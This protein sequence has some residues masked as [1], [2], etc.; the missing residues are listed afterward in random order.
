MILSLIYLNKLSQKE[1]SPVPSPSTS[2]LTS[3][4]PPQQNTLSASPNPFPSQTSTS[5]V[6]LSTDANG[7]S[8][9]TVVIQTKYG[10]IKF[11]F[12]PN[13]APETTKRIIELIQKGFYT[14]LKFHRVETTFVVQGGDPTGTGM[15]GSGQKLKA[16]FN[17]HRHIEGTVAMA[18]SSDPDSA[19][20]QFYISLGT[21]PHLDHS[22]TIFGQ[23][24]EGMDIV[25]KIQV[26]DKMLTVKLE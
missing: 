8:K 16:E 23:V 18:R 17:N 19:D 14:D 20:S 26:G 2:N 1:P 25:R 12:Y 21:H 7:L 24:F 22:Y 11:K 13:D 6:D 15:G 5:P 3:P 4:T 9:T 10:I